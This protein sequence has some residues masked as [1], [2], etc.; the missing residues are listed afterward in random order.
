MVMLCSGIR[1]ALVFYVRACVRACVCVC[2]GCVVRVRVLVRALWREFIVIYVCACAGFR[3]Y[4]C[5]R[6][7]M[8]T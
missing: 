7:C 4:K 6:A 3:V 8:C 2:L 5:A 1:S